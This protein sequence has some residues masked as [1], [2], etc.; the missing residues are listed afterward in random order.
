MLAV[1]AT[2]TATAT[3]SAIMAAVESESALVGST[4]GCSDRDS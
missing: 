4:P 3:T 2:S 1:T